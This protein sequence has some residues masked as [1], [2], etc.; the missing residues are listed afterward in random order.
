MGHLTTKYK[1]C[2]YVGFNALMKKFYIKSMILVENLLFD[3]L[4]FMKT[5][6]FYKKLN[7]MFFYKKKTL[8]L[9][10]NISAGAQRKEFSMHN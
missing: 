3:V 8:F 2:I 5:R 9:S 6:T 1:A 7:K 4:F 10:S